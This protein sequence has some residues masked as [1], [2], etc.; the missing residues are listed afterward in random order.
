[1]SAFA[2][3]D[4]LFIDK[5]KLARLGVVAEMGVAVAGGF[6]FNGLHRRVDAFIDA[7]FFRQRHRAEVQLAKDAAALPLAS[8]T[9]AVAHFLV[10]EPVH[11]MSLASAALFRRGRDGIFMREESEGWET[12][13]L[14]K[15]DATDE[16]LLM[17][18]Q[19]ENGPISLSDHA[20]RTAG[21]P[22][23]PAR[24]VLGLPIIARRELAA[25][26]FYGSHLHGEGLD[27]DEIRAIAGLAS[28]AAAAYDHLEAE[29]LRSENE[30]IR[31]RNEALE[32]QLAQAQIQPA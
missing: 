7:I 31:R 3:V 24:P 1:M 16:P 10:R 28:G 23:G 8:T 5:L 29:K 32:A 12:S 26:V 17:L 13:H 22:S 21:V 6:W 15:L 20:W 4:W 18:A 25:I 30:S 27:P 19:A 14:L 2:L 9:S 11:A